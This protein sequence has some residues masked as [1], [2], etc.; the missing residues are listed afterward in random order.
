MHS[1]GGS[2]AARIPVIAVV[3]GR[4]VYGGAVCQEA[5]SAVM[6]DETGI[7]HSKDKMKGIHNNSITAT[8]IVHKIYASRIKVMR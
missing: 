5:D 8:N 2:N 6:P 1:Y 3:P 7:R 4:P